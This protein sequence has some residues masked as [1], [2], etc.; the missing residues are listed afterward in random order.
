MWY[1]RR[2]GA[3]ELRA[4]CRYTYQTKK[5]GVISKVNPYKQHRMAKEC[6]IDIIGEAKL[7]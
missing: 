3:K 6:G 2:I 1:L 4:G 7:F 5:D